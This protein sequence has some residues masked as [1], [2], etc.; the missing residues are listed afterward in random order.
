MV[1]IF[2]TIV[3][4]KVFHRPLL[5][6]KGTSESIFTDVVQSREH[7]GTSNVLSANHD[8]PLAIL[9]FLA[10][11]QRICERQNIR[12]DKI[13]FCSGFVDFPKTARSLTVRENVVSN[14]VLGTFLIYPA[15]LMV[16]DLIYRLF[17]PNT[18][19]CETKPESEVKPGVHSYSDAAMGYDPD[20][21]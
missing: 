21:W 3:L 10:A 20:T 15:P 17:S 19:E 1:L 9:H 13:D 7:S 8:L 5:S 16:N 11:P 18:A 4:I 6:S 2:C 14:S 12:F